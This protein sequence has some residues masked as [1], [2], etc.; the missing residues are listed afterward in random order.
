MTFPFNL[1]HPL[2]DATG[3][4]V[5]TPLFDRPGIRIERIVSHGQITPEDAPYCQ[6]HDEWVLLLSG[7]ARL[8]QERGD[9]QT[10][11]PGDTLLIPAHVRHR[12]TW[13]TSDSPTIWLAV[14]IEGAC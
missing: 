3:A 12:V 1:L 4:E 5:F 8:W 14:H 7:A 9:E 10:L 6:P 11:R 2:P 13:T